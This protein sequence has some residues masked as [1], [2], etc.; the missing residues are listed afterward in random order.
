MTDKLPVDPT[1]CRPSQVPR[2]PEIQLGFNPGAKHIAG[3]DLDADDFCHIL[4]S[5]A[6]A[7]QFKDSNLPPGQ[8]VYCGSI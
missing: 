8:F 1:N 2:A 4:P 5:G 6:N 7:Y 3:A